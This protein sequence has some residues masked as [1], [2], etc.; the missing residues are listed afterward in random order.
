MLRLTTLLLLFANFCFGQS[1]D[2]YGGLNLHR[3]M[4]FQR[5]VG[6]FRATYT[7]GKEYSFGVGI[8]DLH[9]EKLN[10]AI[11]ITHHK[12]NSDIY[13]YGGGRGG[14][15]DI[16]LSVREQL[17]ALNLYPHQIKLFK[18]FVLAPGLWI[19]YTYDFAM[20]GTTY[21][22]GINTSTNPTSA[23]YTTT[24]YQYKPG[25]LQKWSTG[26][27]G[28]LS[29]K[30]NLNNYISLS[31]KYVFDLNV[32][33]EI[34]VSRQSATVNSMRNLFFLTLNYNFNKKTQEL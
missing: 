19:A 18:N 1:I 23:N 32:V 31:P 21:S 22:W 4:D 34:Y 3:Y 14:G 33:E 26:I 11:S 10:P 29:Y 24:T 30:I 6:H 5:E 17:I 12:T 8:N 28:F 25:E 20:Y 2:V 13:Q 7:Y 27:S 9:L 15:S 16:D